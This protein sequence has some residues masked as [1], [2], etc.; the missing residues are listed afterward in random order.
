MTTGGAGV[1]RWLSIK[2]SW[3]VPGRAPKE[4][5]IYI[6]NIFSQ[7][8]HLYIEHVLLM[9]GMLMLVHGAYY[10]KYT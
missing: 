6:G 3:K 9:M 2:K 10:N 4:N 5:R 1:I 7:N 8:I